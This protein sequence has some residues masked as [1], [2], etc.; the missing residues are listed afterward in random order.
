MKNKAFF[1]ADYQGLRLDQGRT[2]IMTVPT[3]LMRQGNFSEV[4]DVVYDPVTHL[5]FA[6][7]IIPTNRIN[8]ISRVIANDIYP[9]PNLPG[10]ANNRIDNLVLTQTV[11]AGDARVDYRMSDRSSLFARFSMAKRDYDDEAP[12]NIFMGNGAASATNNSDEQL[13]RR[14]R[15][16][17]DARLEQV[18]R[19]PRRLQPVLDPPVRGGLR[20]REE[21]RARH[22]QREPGRV[23][24][25]LGPGQL[26]ARG[27]REHGLSGDD[28]RDP[29]RHHLQP[30]GQPVLDPQQPQL[31]GRNGCPHRQRRGVE[32]ADAAPGPLHLRPQLH[33]QRRRHR[34]RATRSRP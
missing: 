30:H 2:N 13:Q 27:L 12:G 25:D 28:E 34:H 1:F 24:R 19:V 22:P 18:L 33:E 32:P 17:A 8:P 3:L 9:E 6:G 14:D 20:D 16:H 15:L 7:N 29:R 11:N 10:L 21:Q 26:P 4:R 31:Q 23:S 5:P